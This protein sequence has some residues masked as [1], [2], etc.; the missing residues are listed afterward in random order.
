MYTELKE[1]P[2]KLKSLFNQ[3]YYIRFGEIPKNE[4]S[5]IYKGEVKIGE[6]LGVSVYDAVY[7]N[8][9]WRI[10]LPNKLKCEIGFDL[11]N[12]ISDKNRKIYLVMGD[13]LSQKGS[14]NEPLIVNVKIIKELQK[15]ICFLSELFFIYNISIIKI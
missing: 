10:V 14:T 3:K 11:Y 4:R 2:L 6:E 1:K 13:E 8:N 12:F 7:I 5:S 15:E 9:Y